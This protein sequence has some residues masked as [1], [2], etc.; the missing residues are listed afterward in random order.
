M[1]LPVN[2]VAAKDFLKSIGEPKPVWEYFMNML[3]VPRGSGNQEGVRNVLIQIGKNLGC[4]VVVD[5]SGNVLIKKAAAPGLENKPGICLQGHMDMVCEKNSDLEHDFTR[6]PIKPRIDGKYVKATGTS[7][8]ADNGIGVAAMLAVLSDKTLKHGPL[9]CLFTYDEETG[10]VGAS[11]LEAGLL[12]SKFLINCDSEEENSICIGCA[13]GF[14]TKFE[15]AVHRQVNPE[16]AG[17]HIDISG[18]RGG[19]TGVDIA[20][21]RCNVIKLAARLLKIASVKHFNPQIIDIDGGTAHNAIPRE[22]KLDVAV[23]KEKVEA[24]KELMTE[25]FAVILREFRS[26]DGNGSIVL[27]DGATS[28]FAPCTLDVT[29]RIINMLNLL[30]FG[31]LRMSP[32]VKDLVETSYAVTV[33]R[34]SENLLF[35]M[36]SGR[37]SSP[38][39]IQN[40]K[41]L[42][43]SIMDGVGVKSYVEE[44]QY[45]GWQPVPT[46]HLL[47]T[48]KKVHF[49]VTG[50]EPMVY[51]IHAG[52]ECGI[53]MAPYPGMEAISIGPEIHNPHS[54]AEELLISSVAPFYAFLRGTI[55]Q[56]AK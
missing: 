19:H 8:G 12:K 9:E 1:A 11:K 55:E 28:G 35:V 23:S 13:G 2:S 47:L 32:D 14:T 48:A 56:L 10:L 20:A 4:D 30:P 17:V 18:F 45:P 25:E 41:L 42:V 22:L 44:N 31:V 3:E 6:D 37:S 46:S 26:V 53:I 34:A 38:S 15:I 24:F 40:I 39:Q 21:N 52:L 50:K 27:K 16:L 51:A 7:L 54:P 5:K 36:G 49:D 29:H 43:H 33:V